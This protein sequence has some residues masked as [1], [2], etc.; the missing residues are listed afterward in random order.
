MVAANA[1]STL[2]D[3]VTRLA[4]VVPLAAITPFIAA[5]AASTLDEELE[6]EF[7]LTLMAARA[8]SVLA[9]DVEKLTLDA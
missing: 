4:L 3:D 8:V 9:E 6:I 2:V 1:L 5:S 7:E